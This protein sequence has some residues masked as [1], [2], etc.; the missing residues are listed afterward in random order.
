MT[1]E[2][3]GMRTLCILAGA[4]ALALAAACG[5]DDDDDTT[6]HGDHG[7]DAAG[8]SGGKAGSAGSKAGNGGSKAG[9]EGAGGRAG[10]PANGGSGGKAGA[11]SAGGTGGRAGSGGSSSGEREVTISF[12]A[13]VGGADFACGKTFAEQGSKLTT[14]EPAD[15]RTFVQDVKL[16]DDNDK[17]VPLKLK[18][19]APWQSETV[20]LLDFEDAKGKCGGEGTPETNTKIVGTVPEGNYKAIS[21]VNGVPEDLNHDDPTQVADPLKTY[22]S[23]S[24]GWLFGFRFVKLEVASVT[25]SADLDAGA[26]LVP[27]G[28]F[29]LGSTGCTANGATEDGGVDLET[30][31]TCTKS[32]RNRVRLDNYKV[33]ESVI[34]ADISKVFADTDLTVAE[35]CHSGGTACPSM[36]TS[37]GVNLD[38]GKALNSQTLYRLE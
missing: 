33:G 18:V 12:K 9:T 4:A 35:D 38:D 1:N 23:L 31:I 7:H 17:E 37:V 29:H 34:V 8:A 36:F 15:F 16:I 13:K 28:V 5:D 3:T 32:N 10:A 21:F 20:A 25:S 2:E 22:S 6:E 26:E 14:I 24:W 27:G 30:P 11:T 19:S